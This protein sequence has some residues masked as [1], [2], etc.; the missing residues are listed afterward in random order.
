MIKAEHSTRISHSVQQN[1][2][3]GPYHGPAVAAMLVFCGSG[4]IPETVMY[5]LK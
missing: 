3:A 1:T 5:D 2:T 4:M